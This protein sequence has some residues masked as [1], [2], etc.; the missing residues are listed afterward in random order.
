[1]NCRNPRLLCLQ[2]MVSRLLLLPFTRLAS[3]YH[4]RSRSYIHAT[5]LQCIH[6]NLYTILVLQIVS[7]GGPS[8]DINQVVQPGWGSSP[9]ADLQISISS[10]G[11]ER[12]LGLRLL[13]LPSR[14]V[15]AGG[16]VARGRLHLLVVV[17]V[18]GHLPDLQI[19]KC[20]L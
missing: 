1:M 4:L 8:Q 18:L 11:T 2:E 19:V 16:A 13:A 15:V 17:D 20:K 14:S 5:T 12:D 3:K 10:Q 7:F 6:I 9:F